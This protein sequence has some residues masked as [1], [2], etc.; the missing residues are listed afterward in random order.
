MDKAASNEAFYA[1]PFTLNENLKNIFLQ[2]SHFFKKIFFT[3]YLQLNIPYPGQICRI[4]PSTW[5]FDRWL[6]PSSQIEC[7]ISFLRLAK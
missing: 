3:A 4:G 6:S 2:I 7:L 1:R 5:L